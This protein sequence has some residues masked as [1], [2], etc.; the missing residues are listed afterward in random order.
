MGTQSGRESWPEELPA[1]VAVGRS[2]AVAE[3]RLSAGRLFWLEQRPL[4]RG[5]TTLML[6]GPPGG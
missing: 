5:R 4:E 3:P 2:A 1:A 6:A